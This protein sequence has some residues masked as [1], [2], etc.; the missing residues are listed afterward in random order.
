MNAAVYT[1]DPRDDINP[2]TECAYGHPLCKDPQCCDPDACHVE[3]C[4][5]HDETSP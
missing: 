5:S 4:P 1:G 2:D 3:D